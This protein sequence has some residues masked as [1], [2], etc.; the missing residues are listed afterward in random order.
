MNAEMMDKKKAV[1]DIRNELKNYYIV[2][3]GK[4]KYIPI[5]KL[6]LDMGYN[7]GYVTHALTDKCK[8]IAKWRYE[9]I[10][11]HIPYFANKY[12]YNYEKRF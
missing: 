1:E 4:R 5:S 3:N 2:V 9:Q 10:M 7:E 11:D 8:K 6:S 12:G